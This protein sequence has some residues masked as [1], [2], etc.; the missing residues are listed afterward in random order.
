MHKDT[1]ATGR[2]RTVLLA[3]AAGILAMVAAGV[4]VKATDSA[5]FCAGCHAMDEVAWTHK[6]SVHKQFDCA[7]CHLPAN[8]ASKMPYKTQIGLH[9]VFVNTTASVPSV[10]Y[11]S[12]TM[13]DVIQA[14]CRRCHIGTTQDVAMDVKPYCTDCHRSVPHNKKTPIDRRKAADA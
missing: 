7:E 2:W 4:T 5:A 11:A 10:M 12:Q 1:G 3:F 8:L 13:K 6:Q 14:N 9:D